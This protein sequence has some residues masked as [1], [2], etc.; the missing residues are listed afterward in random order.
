AQTPASFKFQ[1][2]K[3]GCVDFAGG[4]AIPKGAAHPIAAQLA[5]NELISAKAGPTFIKVSYVS[6]TNLDVPVQTGD[7]AG[8][9]VASQYKSL[10]LKEMPTKVYEHLDS[11][12]QQ[13]NSIASGS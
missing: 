2:V 7:L 3:E 11:W 4:Y 10:G 5:I 13:Y 9:A 1:P 12:V 8:V 6:N